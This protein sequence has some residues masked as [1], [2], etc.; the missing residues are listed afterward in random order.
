MCGGIN[1]ASLLNIPAVLEFFPEISDICFE[2][3]NFSSS[4][5]PKNRKE[6]HRSIG[7]Q[8]QTEKQSSP[9]LHEIKRFLISESLKINEVLS[10]NKHDENILEIEGISLTYNKNNKGPETL[11]CGTPKLIF[12]NLE[13]ECPTLTACY[14]S[15]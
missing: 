10:A 14:L 2:N 15:L 1:S 5:T 6:E 12:F 11:P 3:F 13:I 7:A 4:S 8:H 9:R